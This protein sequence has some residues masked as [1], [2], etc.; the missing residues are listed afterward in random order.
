MIA[1]FFHLFGLRHT[2]KLAEFA[3]HPLK[4]EDMNIPE[5]ENIFPKIW[6]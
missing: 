3:W 2:N 1:P 4:R 6:N 5:L